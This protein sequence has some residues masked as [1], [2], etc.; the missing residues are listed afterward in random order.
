MGLLGRT[1]QPSINRS[2]RRLLP[3]VIRCL[4][5]EI[6]AIVPRGGI[7]W[8]LVGVVLLGFV[9][10]GCRMSADACDM[11]PVVAPDEAQPNPKPVGRS[12]EW[13]CRAIRLQRELE[14]CRDRMRSHWWLFVDAPTFYEVF[15]KLDPALVD[16]GWKDSEEVMRRLPGLLWEIWRVTG[17][18]PFQDFGEDHVDLLLSLPKSAEEYR[19][20]IEKAAGKPESLLQEEGIREAV[21][22]LET[23]FWQSACE[24]LWARFDHPPASE[25]RAMER[26]EGMPLPEDRASALRMEVQ[27]WVDGNL[28]GLV[29]DGASGKFRRAD[30]QKIDAQWLKGAVGRWTEKGERLAAGRPQ[31]GGLT[32][33]KDPGRQ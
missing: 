27:A 11:R 2:V 8:T 17:R 21:G 24:Y 9:A 29:W 14:G 13:Y 5:H 33:C 20:F 3:T 16:S 26:F 18:S 31:M 12:T 10:V 32:T 22:L 19:A 1:R 28:A 4:L 25:V 7:P 15:P 30:G 6:V 23:R